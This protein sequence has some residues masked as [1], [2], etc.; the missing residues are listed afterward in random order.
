MP[1]VSSAL[2]IISLF[3]VAVAIVSFGAFATEQARDGSKKTVARLADEP[4]SEAVPANP[5]EINQASPA[6][7][8]ERAREQQ[9]GTLRERIDDVNDELTAP[10]AG[11]AG[12]DSVWAQRV[13]TTL[14]VL[15]VFGFGLGFLSRVAAARGV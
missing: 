8:T 15:A 2:R 11:L 4:P 14:L 7:R 13:V 1:V 9:H 10:F 6:P 12:A 5:V 3:C